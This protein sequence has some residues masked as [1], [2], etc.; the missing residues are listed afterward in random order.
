MLTSVFLW[1][2]IIHT[3]QQQQL[4]CPTCVYTGCIV[5]FVSLTQNQHTAAVVIY[6]ITEVNR[7]ETQ[8]ERH[9][10]FIHT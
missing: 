2:D 1:Q 3:K 8:T 7:V 9:L 6:C 5:V 10:A 4:Q